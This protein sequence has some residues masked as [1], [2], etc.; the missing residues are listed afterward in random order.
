MISIIVL[1]HN[2]VEELRANLPAL[3]G[4]LPPEME[5][6][7]VDNASTDGS[8]EFLKELRLRYTSLRILFLDQNMGPPAGRNAGF[9]VARGEYIVALD[10]DASMLVNDIRRVPELFSMHKNSGILA[11]SVRHAKT[12]ERQNDHGNKA[13]AVACFHEAAHAIRKKLF[14]IVGYTDEDLV[15]GAEGLDFSVRCHAA[16]YPTMYLPEVEALHN[17]F[18]RSGPL[19]VYRREKWI[20]GY[21]RTLFKYFPMRMAY[22]YSFRYTILCFLWSRTIIDLPFVARML[23]AALLGR[24]QGKMMHALVPA[25]TVRFYSDPTLF[26]QYGNV[27]VNLLKRFSRKVIRS[28]RR[29][30]VLGESI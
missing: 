5:L 14:D 11:F 28:W 9:R 27:P 30:S 12:G 21:V 16:G 6:I 1:S 24:R 4:E 8:R 3:L 22:L 25:E 26:P 13:V 23:R 10:D 18:P 19:G 17:P 20:Y 29:W 15:F 2:R 7:V